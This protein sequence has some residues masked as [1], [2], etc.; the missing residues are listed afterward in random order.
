MPSDNVHILP[1]YRSQRRFL[2]RGTYSST[3]LR[4]KIRLGKFN[5]RSFCCG[6]FCAIVA[7]S[8]VS[9]QCFRTKGEIYSVRYTTFKLS[10]ASVRNSVKI[11]NIVFCRTYCSVTCL[12][13]DIISFQSEFYCKP[14]IHNL[15]VRG[16]CD[17]C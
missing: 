16:N 1:S 3:S 2:L 12:M 7:H 8:I 13:Y 4:Q 5:G 14:K 9:S 10:I 17:V 6:S 11:T 15:H